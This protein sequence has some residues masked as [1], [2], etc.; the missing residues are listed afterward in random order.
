MWFPEQAPQRR[1]DG[2]RA[3][4]DPAVLVEFVG[5]DPD[6]IRS[7]LR[8]YR[9]SALTLGA[10]IRSAGLAGSGPE[11]ALAAH[12][13]KSSSRMAGASKLGDLCE[14]TELQAESGDLQAIRADMPTLQA[15]L[16]AVLAWLD[17]HLGPADATEGRS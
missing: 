1:R 5:P 4:L 9:H 8:D 3:P 2:T 13:L 7:L 17:A 10:Q 6:L 11:I 14:R 12:K 16:D 15:E